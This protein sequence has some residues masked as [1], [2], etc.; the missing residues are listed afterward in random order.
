M[1]IKNKK[2]NYWCPLKLFEHNTNTVE[3]LAW[4]STFFVTFVFATKHL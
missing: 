1:K 2:K 4:Y 3:F